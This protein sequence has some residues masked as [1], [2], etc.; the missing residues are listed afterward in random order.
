[1]PSLFNQGDDR[2]PSFFP[3]VK[4]ITAA[5]LRVTLVKLDFVTV[6]QHMVHSQ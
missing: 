5:E 4:E 6:D 1:M 2:T 3:A